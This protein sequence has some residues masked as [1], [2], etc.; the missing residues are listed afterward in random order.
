MTDNTTISKEWI[1]I[2][3]KSAETMTYD[4]P[5]NYWWVRE[6]METLADD[7]W[8]NIKKHVELK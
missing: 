4:N 5:E 6:H 2:I 1:D 7:L 8:D 3:D